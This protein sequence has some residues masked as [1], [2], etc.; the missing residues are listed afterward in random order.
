MV[1]V[2]AAEDVDDFGKLGTLECEDTDGF[3]VDVLEPVVDDGAGIM[4]FVGAAQP[5]MSPVSPLAACV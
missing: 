5:V 2:D 1:V 3:D 4:A